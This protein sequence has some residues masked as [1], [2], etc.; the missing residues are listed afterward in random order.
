MLS[1]A[2]NQKHICFILFG[3]KRETRKCVSICEF[4]FGRKNF[5]AKEVWIYFLRKFFLTK[6]LLAKMHKKWKSWIKMKKRKKKLSTTKNVEFGEKSTYT[7]S[8]AQYPQVKCRSFLLK[9]GKKQ[10]ICFGVFFQ[11]QILKKKSLIY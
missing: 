3:A 9:K 10:N 1:I 11:N 7:P 5:F 8:Y 4:G 2:G 6:M